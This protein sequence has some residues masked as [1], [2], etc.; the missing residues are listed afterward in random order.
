MSL[1]PAVENWSALL[2]PWPIPPSGPDWRR[3]VVGQLPWST[4]A[5]CNER[6]PT[7]STGRAVDWMCMSN[8]GIAMWNDRRCTLLEA[9][10]VL[11]PVNPDPR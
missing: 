4:D 11:V 1:A 5:V 3:A 8:V 6:R 10:L 7:R 2:S 9:G